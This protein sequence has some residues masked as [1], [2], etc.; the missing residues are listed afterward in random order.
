VSLLESGD[1]GKENRPPPP[2]L[3]PSKC[4]KHPGFMINKYLL[5]E[6][7][8]PGSLYTYPGPF[9]Q[10]LE[11]I[12]E[13]SL[14]DFSHPRSS[15]NTKEQ[16]S[17]NLGT[18]GLLYQ[19]THFTSFQRHIVTF[20]KSVF[21]FTIKVSLLHFSFPAYSPFSVTFRHCIQRTEVITIPLHPGTTANQ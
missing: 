6:A 14:A 5:T 7:P 18:V 15:P 10:S 9:K 12:Q 4:N 8:Q 19:T 16:D 3:R 1:N 20:N 11:C 21:L 2:H 17:S 13:F